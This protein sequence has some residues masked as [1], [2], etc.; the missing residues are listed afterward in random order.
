M[1]LLAF[2]LSFVLF[3]KAIVLAADPQITRKVYF[4]IQHGD[5]EV[6]RIVVGL[7][8]ATTPKTADNF[9]ELTISQDPAMG[10][11]GSIFHRVIPQFM[12][13]GGDFTDGTGVG[14]KSIYGAS[15]PD[16]NFDVKHDRP[17]RLSMANRG[18]DTNGSQFFI[19]TVATPWLDGRHVVFGEVL[20]GMDVVHYI[21]NVPRDSRDAPLEKVVIAA[22]GEAETVPLD[23]QTVQHAQEKARDE[24]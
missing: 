18:K 1:Q 9:Y 11:L 10:Y 2:A 16:E 6:G 24:L 19:T 4:D 5:K 7:Y 13:Q 17:G 20:E 8:G 23:N 15:F 12:I 21:E 22:C 14:G 3:F